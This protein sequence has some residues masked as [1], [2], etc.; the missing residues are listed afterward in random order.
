[1]CK[2]KNPKRHTI[3]IIFHSEGL[4]HITNPIDHANAA[5]GRSTISKAHRK[6]GHILHS[7]IKNAVTK[8][9]II[10][11]ELENDSKPE[12]C[13]ACAK[14]KSARQPFP[15]ESQMRATKYGGRVHW[16]LWG[17]A[18]VKSLNGHHYV[19]ARIN[20]ATHKTM[21]YF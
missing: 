2:I 19:A 7:A 4:Y 5:S 15:K 17:P 8:G 18:S 3:A 11:I 14:A 12:F 1:M 16:N 10:G 6:L 21:L 9:Y 20:D 13:D